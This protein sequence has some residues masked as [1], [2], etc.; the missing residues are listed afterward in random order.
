MASQQHTPSA[1]SLAQLDFF[2]DV[3]RWKP[4]PGFEGFYEASN[5]GNVR[6]LTRHYVTKK[7][8]H[9]VTVQG[10]ILVKQRGT[11][12]RPKALYRYVNLSKEGVVYRRAIHQLVLEAFIGPRSKG[13]VCNHI[14]G[15]PSNNALENLEWVTWQRNAEDSVE[16]GTK[17]LLQGE[18][19]PG[20]RFTTAQILA[21]R[22]F[23]ATGMSYAK[24]GRYFDTYA[25]TIS[26]I[27]RRKAWK[28][29][30]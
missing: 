14:D 23:A 30:P 26:R 13:H 29:I 27:V 22:E 25:T 11:K 17:F 2:S 4:I 9:H 15:N 16:R 10:R 19:H 7:K 3:E 12:A 6:S 8:H 18:A 21:I 20:A 1:L 28:H 5:R 24:I